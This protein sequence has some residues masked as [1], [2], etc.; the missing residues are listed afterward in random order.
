MLQI[1]CEAPGL[2]NCPP[3]SN[4]VLTLSRL[5][6]PVAET[7]INLRVEAL[8]LPSLNQRDLL[9]ICVL[10]QSISHDLGAASRSFQVCPTLQFRI[11]R[12]DV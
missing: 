1:Q 7:V 10:L 8:K 12:P 6:L 9:V 5:L 11:L 2:F 4:L 3:F